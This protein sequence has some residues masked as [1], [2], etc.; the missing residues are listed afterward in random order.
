MLEQEY[1][2]KFAT[3][4]QTG[5]ELLETPKYLL[6]AV[7]GLKKM[8][9]WVFLTPS[10]MKSQETELFGTMATVYEGIGEQLI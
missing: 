3:V 6:V 5:W 9:L 4:V 2:F 1:S 10:L 7:G 8:P